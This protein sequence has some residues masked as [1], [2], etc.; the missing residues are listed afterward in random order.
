MPVFTFLE[1]YEFS[2][3]TIVPFCTHEGSGLGR[4]VSDIR[5]A[6]QGATVL[7]GLAIRGGSVRGA[8]DDVRRWVVATGLS[9]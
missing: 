5:K 2:G 1:S 7:G 8:E 6:C 9:L 3:K 4:S